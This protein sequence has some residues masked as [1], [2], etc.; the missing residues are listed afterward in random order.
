MFTKLKG[1]FLE[2]DNQTL[3]FVRCA[4]AVGQVAYFGL[5]GLAI[6]HNQPIDWLSWSGGYTALIVGSAAGA[7][8]K[9]DTEAPSQ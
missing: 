2:R 5:T 9:L 7:R 1:L 6:Y 3:C 4:V 8:I